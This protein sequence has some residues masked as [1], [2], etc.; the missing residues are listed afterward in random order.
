M[1]GQKIV[2]ETSRKL[3]G[4]FEAVEFGSDDWNT[5]TSALNENIDRYNKTAN[6]R[7]SYNPRY[8]L[9]T[10]GDSPFY[11]LKHSEISA[12]SG[13]DRAHILF[14]DANDVIV[15]KYKLVDQDIF[16]QS[17]VQDKVVTIN[18]LGL[19]TKPKTTADNIYGTT[20]VLP[21]F[22]NIASISRA[23][24]VVVTDDNYWLITRTAADLSATSPVAFI[25][26]NY[27][28]LNKDADS[29]MR[30]M[31]KKNRVSQSSTP[32]YGGWNPI[33]G[34]VGR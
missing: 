7:T 1:D 17:S 3:N 23:S 25:A 31:K 28:D 13:S 10:V 19:Q 8:S 27:D 33:S 26:R 9:G 34:P 20:I 2:D 18:S 30:A 32:A 24:D 14:Y 15:D 16:D 12:I 6:W 11:K 21:V 22:K 29:R 5:I 4:E